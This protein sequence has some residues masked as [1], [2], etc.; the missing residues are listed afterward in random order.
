MEQRSRP[1]PSSRE[2]PITRDISKL[3][4]FDLTQEYET[5]IK[6]DVCN[7]HKDKNLNVII[8]S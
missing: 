8:F 6:Y 5:Y 2:N 4:M 1:F 3:R 7:L